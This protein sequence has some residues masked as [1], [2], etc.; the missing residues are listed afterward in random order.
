MRTWLLLAIYVGGG[1]SSSAPLAS[2]FTSFP[3]RPDWPIHYTVTGQED[4]PPLLLLPGF[5]V[6]TFHWE[7]Q[8]DALSERYRVFSMDLLGQGKSWPTS[9]TGLCYSSQLWVDQIHHFCE[10]VVASPVHVAGNSLGGFLSV[11]AASSRPDLFK[12]LILL[13]AAPF[14]GFASPEGQERSFPFT[15]WNGT[16][17]APE[18]VLQFGSAYFNTMKSRTTVETML[19]GVYKQ[20]SAFDDQLVSD[21]V[22]SASPPGSGGQEAFTSI[23]FSPRF[24]RT[25]D[26]MLCS[27]ELESLPTCLV[28]GKDDPWI[29]PYWAQR[30]IKGLRGRAAYLEIEGSGHC[31]HHESPLAVNKIITA[32]VSLIEAEREAKGGLGVAGRGAGPLAQHPSLAALEGEYLEPITKSK[33]TV[34]LRDGQP[35]TLWERV[36]R[37]WDSISAPAPAPARGP[38]PGP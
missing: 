7:R 29:V 4:A 21:I 5:G 18:N 13:N 33:V 14:W 11:A 28:Y 32:W 20:R 1:S 37:A 34:R 15:L 35:Q 16:L 17:P 22:A 9:T 6:G 36:M 31:P 30:A 25:F 19:S 27:P 24:G 26:E 8:M 23:L 38:A 3:G 10:E 2:K 12:S